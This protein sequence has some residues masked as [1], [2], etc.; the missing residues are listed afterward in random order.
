MLEAITKRL[1]EQVENEELTVEGYSF[2]MPSIELTNAIIEHNQRLVAEASER[3]FPAGYQSNQS[4]PQ[5]EDSS[6]FGR[7][8]SVL[9]RARGV[10]DRRRQ[11]RMGQLLVSERLYHYLSSLAE[12]PLAN[13]GGDFPIWEYLPSGMATML[14][15]SAYREMPADASQSVEIRESLEQ[16]T[17]EFRDW[18]VKEHGI[19]VTPWFSI[20]LTE[21]D[22]LI[23]EL[24]DSPQGCSTVEDAGA[25]PVAIEIDTADSEVAAGA[26]VYG[27]STP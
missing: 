27:A 7:I 2:F 23:L 12:T 16:L 4:A 13:Q 5:I 20:S 3:N 22:T 1:S 19:F 10:P 21:N 9:L 8:E 24:D 15:L 18:L 17:G 26:R 14:G 6:L 11:T 25:Y